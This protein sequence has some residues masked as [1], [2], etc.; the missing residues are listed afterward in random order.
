M[1]DLSK[2]ASNK[3]VRDSFLK[4]LSIKLA[5]PFRGLRVLYSMHIRLCRV[6]GSPPFHSTLSQEPEHRPRLQRA[7]G[8]MVCPSTCT[9]TYSHR[10]ASADHVL[11]STRT[12]C[13]CLSKACLGNRGNLAWR[14]DELTQ[15][16]LPPIQMPQGGQVTKAVAIRGLRKDD[17]II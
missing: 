17:V 3:T 1:L 7:P 2:L 5:L 15:R 8:N 16:L 10:L 11:H 9:H 4:G 13:C 6:R 14:M 12:F